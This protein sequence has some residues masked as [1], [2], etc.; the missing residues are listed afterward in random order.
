M[1][2]K[3]IEMQ[4]IHTLYIIIRWVRTEQIMHLCIIW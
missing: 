3:Y 2:F 1:L 4:I